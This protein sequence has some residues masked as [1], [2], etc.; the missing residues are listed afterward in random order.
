MRIRHCLPQGRIWLSLNA[1]PTQSLPR[2]TVPIRFLGKLFVEI[3][4]FRASLGS[5]GGGGV[6][7]EM[8]KPAIQWHVWVRAFISMFVLQRM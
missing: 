3:N 1:D 2:C 7:S 4:D 6:L 8:P 5:E